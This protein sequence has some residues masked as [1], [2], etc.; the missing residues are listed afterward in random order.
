VHGLGA[1]LAGRASVLRMDLFSA[2]GRAF[3]D[4]YDLQTVPAIVVLDSSGTVRYQASGGL[5][6]AP[7]IR[8]AVKALAGR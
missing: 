8:Q 2:D 7:A 1:D 4:R 5:P 6:D 3:F